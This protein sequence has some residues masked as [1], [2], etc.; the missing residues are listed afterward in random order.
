MKEKADLDKKLA[1]GEK[2][3]AVRRLPFGYSD[4]KLTYP[5]AEHVL[6]CRLSSSQSDRISTEDG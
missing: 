4:W 5:S 2:N 3:L 1:T 6:E